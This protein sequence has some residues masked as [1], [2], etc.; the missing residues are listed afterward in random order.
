MGR[1][2]PDREQLDS[3]KDTDLL[4]A[5]AEAVQQ[6]NRETSVV[7]SVNT[8]MTRALFLREELYRRQT[9]RLTRWLVVL[10]VLIALLTAANVALVG[11]TVWNR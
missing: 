1:F 6:A 8:L 11:F 7:Q 5:Y 3:M 10:T 4:D 9:R 2:L